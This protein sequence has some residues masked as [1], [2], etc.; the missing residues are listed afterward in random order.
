MFGINRLYCKVVV[1]ITVILPLFAQ[2]YANSSDDLK[3]QLDKLSNQV[4]YLIQQQNSQKNNDYTQ[5]LND[6]RGQVEM[7]SYKLNQLNKTIT[8]Q[9]KK[10]DDDIALLQQKINKLTASKLR[11][12]RDNAAFDKAHKAMLANQYG[13]SQ[14]LF[15][16]YLSSFYNGEHYSESLYL[17]GQIYLLKGETKNA[18][19]RFSRIV[20]HYPKSIKIA[21]ATYSLGLLEI[22]NGNISKGKKYLQLVVKKYPKSKL[23]A[24]AKKQLE[25]L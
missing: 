9:L 10:Y 14:K 1:L 2:A 22:S 18:Y 21:D 8:I 19:K 3:L 12:Q 11:L 4:N 7:N 20:H 13:V 6:L 17:S 16:Q 23:A 24:K 25:Q 15:G 5:Q